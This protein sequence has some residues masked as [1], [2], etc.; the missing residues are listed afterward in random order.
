[1]L[2]TREEMINLLMLFEV[3]YANDNK[4]SESHLN[5]KSPKQWVDDSFKLYISMSDKELLRQHMTILDGLYED[6]C[7]EEMAIKSRERLELM[8]DS[9]WV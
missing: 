8:K 9:L 1:M 5:G 3:E 6:G 4:D 7:E 2:Y